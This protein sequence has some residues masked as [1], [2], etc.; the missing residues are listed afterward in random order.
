MKSELGREMKGIEKRRF[1]VWSQQIDSGEIAAARYP[2]EAP[3]QRVVEKLVKW[4]RI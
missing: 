1:R 3:N 4:E 2:A